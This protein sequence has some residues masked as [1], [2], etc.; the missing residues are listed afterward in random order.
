MKKIHENRISA[1]RTLIGDALP[2]AVLDLKNIR[3]LTGFEGSNAVMLFTAERV[4]FIT[5]PRYDEYAAGIMPEGVE[6]VVAKGAMLRAIAPLLGA[7]RVYLEEHAATMSYARA[8]A[9]AGELEAVLPAVSHALALRAVKDAGEIEY[10]R[11]A[12]TLA[13][14]CFDHLLKIVRPGMTEWELWIETDLFY[15]RNGARRMGFD[16]IIASGAGSSMPHY[17][18]SMEKRIAPGEMLMIDMG[19]ELDGY[20]S[21]LTR[22]IFIN[23]IPEGFEEIYGIV[24]DAQEAAIRAIAPG[25]I[26][27]AI[28]AVARDHIAA[29]GYGEHFGHSL[30]HGV[31]LDVH[32]QP[33]LKSAAESTLISGN[34]VTVE[35]GIYLPGR[36]GIRIEDMVLVTESGFEILT[37]APKELILI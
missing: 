7:K 19:C 26:A 27:G 37:G 31:G 2:Y 1:L 24:R 32:E 8:L 14:R 30:G 6:L 16:A 34:V 9:E 10:I 29:A 15:K 17:F 36:G 12:V 25:A 3:Y 35:P 21:D 5:D 11:R 22:T 20:N 28:D 18:S 13:D 4:L 23:E 33:Y